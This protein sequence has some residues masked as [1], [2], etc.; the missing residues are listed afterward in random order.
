MDRPTRIATAS[1]NIPVPTNTVSPIKDG[2]IRST[3]FFMPMV[4]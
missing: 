3:P 1:L 4:G 2:K